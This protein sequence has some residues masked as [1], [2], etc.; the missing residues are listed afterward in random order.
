MTQ[1]TRLGSSGGLPAYNPHNGADF[2]AHPL[3][4]RLLIEPAIFFTPLGSDFGC[5]SP[6]QLAKS[7]IGGLFGRALLQP[8]CV[9][10]LVFAESR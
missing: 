2:F 4:V 8:I 6:A 10:T 5:R 3:R 7:L 9:P 1:P